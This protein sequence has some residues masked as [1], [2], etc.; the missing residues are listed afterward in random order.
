MNLDRIT[1]RA[2]GG[3]DT[4]VTM[5]VT[6]ADFLAGEKTPNLVATSSHWGAYPEQPFEL[7][8][9]FRPKGVG[10]VMFTG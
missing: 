9:Q 5:S 1:R 10:P 6:T 2:G 3:A 7:A 4:V 8:L